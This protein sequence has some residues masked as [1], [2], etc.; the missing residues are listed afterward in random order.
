MSD[1]LVQLGSH[2]TA[3][4]LIQ[5]LGL[6]IPLPKA[7][8]RRTAPWTTDLLAGR[9]FVLGSSQE[10]PVA[11]AA[12][13]A[14]LAAGATVAE[15]GSADIVVFDASEMTQPSQLADLRQFFGPR[16]KPLRDFGRLLVLGRPSEEVSGLAAVSTQR[17]LEGFVRSLAK[18]V[19]RKGATANFLRVA[20]GAEAALAGPLVWFASDY[21]AFVDG[22]PLTIGHGEP[23]DGTL[24]GK[25]VV[26]TGAARGIGAEIAR[27]L[28]REGAHVLMVD[29]PGDEETLVAA[30]E[31]IGG[32][33]VPCDV[34]ASDAAD[35]L[36]QALPA[37]G[38]D[39]LIHNAGV[40]RD[41][42]LAKMSDDQW[43]LAIAVN[44]QAV[45]DLTEALEPRLNDGGRIVALASVA[46]IA[47]N[48]GQ[49]NYAASKAGVI[50]FVHAASEALLSRNITVNAIAPGFIETRMTA[51]IPVATREGGRRLSALGQGGQPQDVAEAITF[52]CSPAAYGV[53]GNVLR[54]CG[55]ALIGA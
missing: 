46:G 42:T 44:L 53:T 20:E 51:A 37:G 17:A 16:L 23:Q 25:T 50:G 45:I 4:S 39:L 6:P 1:F 47:G 18:E 40:T 28:V 33:A 22:Q 36:A 9:T 13:A 29:R 26:V 15:E 8:R 24:A 7:L 41:R 12:K 10:G 31:D 19:G 54:V 11:E 55:S 2:A 35:V 5:K 48:F 49:T 27:C 14:L 43:D 21:S 3:R 32:I 52:L 30:A 38:L 34:T